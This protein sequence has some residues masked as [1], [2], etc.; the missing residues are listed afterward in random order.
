[1][2]ISE[3]CFCAQHLVGVGKFKIYLIEVGPS[4]AIMA[5]RINHCGECCELSSSKEINESIG[6]SCFI[7]DVE[8]VLLQICGPLMMAVILQWIM[9]SLDYCLLPENVMPPLAIGL[10]NGVH[11]F[12]VSRVL[13]NNI[14]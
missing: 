8:V 14:R 10:K 1:M 9:M 12:F 2:E 4:G 6:N 3:N 5:T 13:T 11:L 7:L